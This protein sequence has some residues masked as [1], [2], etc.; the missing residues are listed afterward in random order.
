MSHKL[1]EE[2]KQS[3]QSAIE[4]AK[5]DLESDDVTRLESGRQSLEAALHQVAEALYKAEAPP[6]GEGSTGEEAASAGAEDED[7]IDAE[8]TEEK[9]DS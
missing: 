2:A 3:L 8:Y 5:K 4:D 6:A 1:G 9:S 7:V